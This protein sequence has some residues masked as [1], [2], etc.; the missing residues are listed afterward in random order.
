MNYGNFCA[1]KTYGL[2]WDIVPVSL[3]GIKDNEKL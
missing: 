3:G 2:Y 1:S